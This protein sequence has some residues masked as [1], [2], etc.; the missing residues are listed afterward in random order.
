MSEGAAVITVPVHG[1][2]I[3]VLYDG[4]CPLC[5]FQTKL[6]TWLDWCSVTRM[7]PFQHEAAQAY[8]AGVDPAELSAAIHVVGRDGRIR[9]SARALRYLGMRMPL[10]VPLALVAWLP[11]VIWVAEAVYALISRNRLQLSSI[12]G[13]QGACQIMPARQRDNDDVIEAQTSEGQ[14]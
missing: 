14:R 10:L 13:C 2:R 3:V 4:R 5:T 9:K 8:V 1:E 11:G 7:V 6:L 12:F